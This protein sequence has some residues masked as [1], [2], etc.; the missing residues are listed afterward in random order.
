MQ[1][2]ETKSSRP[3]PKYLEAETDLRRPSETFGDL[4]RPSETFGDLWRPLET[5]GDLRRPSETFGDLRRPLETFGD[6]RRP[7][8]ETPK[9]GSRDTSRDRDRDQ[10]SRLITGTEP[11]G[12]RQM[13]LHTLAYCFSLGLRTKFQV[14]IVYFQV[15]CN[16]V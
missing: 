9:N 14:Q 8:T 10:V 16:M 12:F 4:W 6:L 7:E 2:L 5:F 1:S 11:A 3:R 15:Y 13:F